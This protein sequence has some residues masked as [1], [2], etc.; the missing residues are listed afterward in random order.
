MK[1]RIIFKSG[2]FY[3]VRRSTAALYPVLQH[4]QIEIC[5]VPRPYVNLI[6]YKIKST[7]KNKKK[8]NKPSVILEMIFELH[9]R[10]IIKKN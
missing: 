7:V 3:A 2:K 8:I 5:S 6:C 4:C 1:Y 10:V 9:K